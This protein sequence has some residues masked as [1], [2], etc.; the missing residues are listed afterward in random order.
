MEHGEAMA[1]AAAV[2]AVAREHGDE[3]E[4][5]RRLAAPVVQTMEASGLA[6]LLAPTALGGSAAH[7]GTVVE[8]I[9]AISAADPSA[10][11]C[12]S[13]GMGA[14]ALLSLIE[15]AEAK[16]VLAY[17]E[18][19]GV[20]VFSPGGRLAGDGG[21]RRLEGRWTFASG[22]QQAGLAGVGAM[23]LGPDGVP[24]F[25]PDGTPVIQIT[26][27]TPDDFE[28]I[29]TW[30]TCGMRG[31]GSH[32]IAVAGTT[33]PEGRSADLLGPKWPDDPTYRMRAFDFLA[34]ALAAVAL[35][36]GRAALDLVA[37]DARTKDGQPVFG[38][39]QPLA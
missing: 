35:G 16:E 31:T 1:A 23:I 15:P 18:R 34:P 6:S 13:I 12:T 9:A 21:E 11:W 27:I 2:G 39:R 30:D 10:G 3:S 26:F 4:R 22:C 38:P 37:A 25:R 5:G 32:D 29:E 17:P 20:G 36:I 19:G 14:N 8:V 33:V 7:P 28:V 24:Q